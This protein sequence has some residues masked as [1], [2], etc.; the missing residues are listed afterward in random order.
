MGQLGGRGLQDFL[1]VTTGLSSSGLIAGEGLEQGAAAGPDITSFQS[2]DDSG[3]KS[4]EFVDAQ[5]IF[6]REINLARAMIADDSPGLN[7]VEANMGPRGEVSELQTLATFAVPSGR[8]ADIDVRHDTGDRMYFPIFGA[9][10][11][12]QQYDLV[13]SDWDFN[14]FPPSN[15]Q[16][17]DLGSVVPV[18]SFF[19]R[20]GT[21]FWVVDNPNTVTAYTMSIPWDITSASAD[22][23]TFDASNEVLFGFGLIFDNSGLRMYISDLEDNIVAS[24]CY[25]YNLSVAFDITTAVYSGNVLDLVSPGASGLWLDPDEQQYLFVIYNGDTLSRARMFARQLPD[26][27]I[28]DVGFLFDAEGTS[29]GTDAIDNSRFAKPVTY[30]GGMVLSNL[31]AEFGLTS[32]INNATNGRYISVDEPGLGTPGSFD[33]SDNSDFTVE[34]WVH[35]LT[36]VGTRD[37]VYTGPSGEFQWGFRLNTALGNIEI[38]YSTDGTSWIATPTLGSLNINTWYYITL[39]RAGNELAAYQDGSK[40]QGATV[41]LTGVSLHPLTT[42]AELRFGDDLD[43]YMDEIRITRGVARYAGLTFFTRPQLPFPIPQP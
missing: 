39:Q 33:F 10:N 25:Q 32:L 28:D 42:A 2:A 9:G 26:A 15:N 16:S 3:D 4:T 43:G 21:K 13:P 11:S 38:L 24:N 5:G 41:D 19:K 27:F 29:G 20:D 6:V 22:G 8:P 36:N 31:E 23:V 37:L 35:Q 18:A 34:F 40:N 12:M 14:I 7:I 1:A 17:F 30:T